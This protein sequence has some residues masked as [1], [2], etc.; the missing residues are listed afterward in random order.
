MNPET[1]RKSV[2]VLNSYLHGVTEL[3]DPGPWRSGEAAEAS[4]IRH[5]L[6]RANRFAGM[7]NSALKGAIPSRRALDRGISIE[8]IRRGLNDVQDSDTRGM[9][10][11]MCDEIQAIYTALML[12]HLLAQSAL[13]SELHGDAS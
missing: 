7:G 3:N 1:V 5:V 6:G 10:S 11:D 2:N 12:H 9:L 8:S 4:T 13:M